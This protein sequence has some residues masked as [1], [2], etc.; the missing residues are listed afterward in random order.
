MR[1]SLFG[2]ILVAM[3][4][5][6]APAPAGETLPAIRD[7]ARMVVLDNGRKKPLDTYARTVLIRLSGKQSCKG[8]SAARWLADALFNPG[9]AWDDKVL[10]I[11]NPE[12]ADAMGVP[13]EKH[14]RYSL[15]ELH[16]GFGALQ[17]MVAKASKTD[18]KSRSSFENEAMRLAANI[19]FFAQLTSAFSF[20]DPDP[21]FDLSDTSVLRY[22]GI[23]AKPSA[24]YLDMVSHAGELHAAMALLEKK[25]EWS[26]IDSA[27][28]N[29]SMAL[30]RRATEA[31]AEPLR[32]LP[33]RNSAE[34]QSPWG[35]IKTLGSS[36]R[37]ETCLSE[38][39]SVKSAY[40]AGDKDRLEKSVRQ[41]N[42]AASQLGGGYPPV[43]RIDL[44]I[45]YNAAK[46][47]TSAKALYL[48]A[49]IAS[50]AAL[51]AAVRWARIAGLA[52]LIAAVVP[53][54]LGV[55]ARMIIMSRPPITN[56][57][58]TFVFVAL[59]CAVLGLVLEFMQRSSLGL[60]V[61]SVS[62]FAFLHLA[63]IYGAD[64]DTM[65]MLAAV[66]NNNFWLATHIITVALGYA[67]CVA[68]GVVGHVYLLQR[69]VRK[70][71]RQAHQST[72]RI[73]YGI[74][75][76]GL[77]FTFV[78]TMLG[79]M[80]ADQSWGRFWGWDPKENGALLIILW[81]AALMHARRGRIIDDRGFAAGT[82]VGLM[83]VMFAWIGVN[84]LGVGL[85]S[86]GFTATGAQILFTVVGGDAAFLLMTVPLGYRKQI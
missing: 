46:P 72:A 9:A 2:V 59:A 63:G 61:G 75:A 18:P 85:H 79:G 33:V 82:V 13:P 37:N 40:G 14:R 30:Y 5:G 69:I 26:H 66:L 73:M 77:T 42:A 71:D 10:L 17:D 58:E 53:H 68:A 86:Y 3:M 27:V 44:E 11:N 24:S 64:G 83:L 47:F 23:A 78:G 48:A 25:K 54:A 67:G 76:F 8:T 39:I 20:L 60:L 7:I 62:G 45:I 70:N 41:F 4:V 31:S 19:D 35:A 49:L 6:T 12:I 21:A 52:L 34:W 51:A 84:L 28:V 43:W 1:H 50:L 56:L 29:L 22:L 32:I 57:Y 38:C 16:P 15:T 81:C 74:L 80:W 55:V 36:A 65:G